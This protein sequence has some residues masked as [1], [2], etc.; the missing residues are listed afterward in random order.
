MMGWGAVVL[1]LLVAANQLWNWG[2][3]MYLWAL[4]VVVWGAMSFK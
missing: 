3:L 4:L 1:G 2:S